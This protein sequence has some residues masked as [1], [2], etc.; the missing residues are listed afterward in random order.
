MNLERIYGTWRWRGYM[1]MDGLMGND[2]NIDI[3]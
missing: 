1:D 2:M 3:L